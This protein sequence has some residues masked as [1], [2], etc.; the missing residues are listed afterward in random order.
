MQAATGH[1]TSPPARTFEAA[2]AIIAYAPGVDTYVTLAPFDS[3]RALVF[4]P[5]AVREH[6]A[7]TDFLPRH[8]RVDARH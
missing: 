7:Q 8:I 5:D 2:M 3:R 6:P 4:R 1:Y